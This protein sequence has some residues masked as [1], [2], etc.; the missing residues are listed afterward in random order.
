M[1]VNDGWG[2]YVE[3]DVR[4]EG[5]HISGYGIEHNQD[6]DDGPNRV[7]KVSNL[8][9]S[10]PEREGPSGN[11]LHV[12]NMLEG[13]IDID[14]EEFETVVVTNFRTEEGRVELLGNDS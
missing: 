1:E 4:F 3:D 5:N 13:T 8:G 10:D 7:A 9:K 6:R 2:L 14:R 11:L 12:R